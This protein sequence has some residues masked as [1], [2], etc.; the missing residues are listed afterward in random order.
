MSDKKNLSDL[1]NS[2]TTKGHW[3]SGE[4]FKIDLAY[5]LKKLYL[6]KDKEG[7]HNLF[8]SYLNYLSR[9]HGIKPDR[10]F[11]QQCGR[12]LDLGAAMADYELGGK[13]IFDA[14][15]I[16]KTKLHHELVSGEIREFAQTITGFNPG[17]GLRGFTTLLEDEVYLRTVG[18]VKDKKDNNVAVG[19][20]LLFERYDEP[21]KKDI[22]N[23]LRSRI[24]SLRKEDHSSDIDEK[25]L[26]NLEKAIFQLDDEVKEDIINESKQIEFLR[27]QKSAISKQKNNPAGQF[28]CIRYGYIPL[29]LLNQKRKEGRL[30]RA[31]L[32][33]LLLKDESLEREG[34]G[35]IWEVRLL[36]DQGSIKDK[37]NSIK[38]LKNLDL[39]GMDVAR[40]VVQNLFEMS[41][42]ASHFPRFNNAI[43]RIYQESSITIVQKLQ[44]GHECL[45]GER[46]ARQF[47]YPLFGSRNSTGLN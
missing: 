42:L 24:V 25:N 41:D 23:Y 22:L 45:K 5:E 21:K 6:N 20:L 2:L 37:E 11:I 46:L 7:M 28:I 1:L 17:I 40:E 33:E 27:L 18:Y 36:Y 19:G 38:E 13:N 10:E 29:P 34:F 8:E 32:Y 14:E 43:Y 31:S 35:R 30:G 47:S 15:H 39:E 9:I 3:A 12:T 44:R 16:I 26:D 4:D